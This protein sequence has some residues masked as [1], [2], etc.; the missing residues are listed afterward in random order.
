MSRGYEAGTYCITFWYMLQGAANSLTLNLGEDNSL[1]VSMQ[2]DGKWRSAALTINP[3]MNFN[4]S[5][6][7]ISKNKAI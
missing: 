4:V 5:T 3:A 1:L 6:N 7:G 2:S